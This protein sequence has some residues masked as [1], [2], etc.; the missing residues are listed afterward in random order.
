MF[1]NGWRNFFVLFALLAPLYLF[2]LLAEDGG[3]DV[4]FAAVM[5]LIDEGTLSIDN[6][7]FGSNHDGVV[8]DYYSVSDGV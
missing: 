5:A 1:R 3:G 4:R 6:Q 7:F 2:F 8:V